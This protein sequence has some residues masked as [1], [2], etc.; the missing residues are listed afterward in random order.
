MTQPAVPT[1]ASLVDGN[2]L[3]R[4]VVSLQGW[5]EGR[6]STSAPLMILT[7]DDDQISGWGRLPSTRTQP[8]PPRVCTIMS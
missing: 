3:C 8:L 5:V 6:V 7:S 1:A 4:A 2:T